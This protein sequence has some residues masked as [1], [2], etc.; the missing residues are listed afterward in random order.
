MDC[1][2]AAR[3]LDRGEAVAVDVREPREWDAGHLRGSLHIPMR[4]L[5]ARQDELPAGTTIVAV[6]RTGNRSGAVTRALRDAGYEAENLEG[7]LKAWVRLGLPLEPPG[8]RVV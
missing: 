4:E 1:E 5:G 7:G 3:L 6:C 2:E 8:G